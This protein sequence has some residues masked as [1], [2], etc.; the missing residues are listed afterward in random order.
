[1]LAPDEILK[2]L[3]TSSLSLMA[4]LIA[5]IAFLTSRYEE[6]KEGPSWIYEPYRRLAQGMIAILVLTAVTSLLNL[7]YLEGL[8]LIDSVFALQ[9]ISTL[10]ALQILGI[11]ASGVIIAVKFLRKHR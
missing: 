4:M 9:I 11:T 6:M 8:I 10:F 2:I 3:L 1:M 7:A 5:I